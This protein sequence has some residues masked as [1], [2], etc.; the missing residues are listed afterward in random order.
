MWHSGYVEPGAGRPG[1]VGCYVASGWRVHTEAVLG[2]FFRRCESIAGTALGEGAFRADRAV[3]VG[4]REVAH[5]DADGMLDVRLTRQAIRAR[6]EELQSDARIVLRSSSSDW[7][8]VSIATPTDLDFAIAL[9][10]EA[11]ANNAPTAEP[12]AP[13]EGAELAR[14]R[15]FH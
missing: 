1:A 6:R 12:G 14:R 9:V 5:F 4:R 13:P 8:A 7:L 3:W 10:T 11:V 2:E 15:R